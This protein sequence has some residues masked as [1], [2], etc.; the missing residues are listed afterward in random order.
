MILMSLSAFMVGPIVA[1]VYSWE[2]TLVVLG[3][4]PLLFYSEKI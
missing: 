3:C 1:F 2:L 4:S